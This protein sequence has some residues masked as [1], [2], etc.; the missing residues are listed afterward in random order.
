MS[1][2]HVIRGSGRRLSVMMRRNRTVIR[3]A[4]RGA[5]RRPE[6]SRER[7]MKHDDRKQTN[8]RKE[9]MPA[10]LV[11]SCHA[12][13]TLPKSYAKRPIHAADQLDAHLIPALQPK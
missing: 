3:S 10:I 8:T 13:Q 1:A 12:S 5:V 7:R 4:A 6:G 11:A 2:I 9:R